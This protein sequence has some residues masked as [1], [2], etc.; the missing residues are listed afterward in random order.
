MN[1]H[2]YCPM[3]P[4]A[5]T[6]VWRAVR[7]TNDHAEDAKGLEPTVRQLESYRLSDP[8]D[9]RS[10]GSLRGRCLART[11]KAAGPLDPPSMPRA[12]GVPVIEPDADT[13][14]AVARPGGCGLPHCLAAR[15]LDGSG[16]VRAGRTRGLQYGGACY[17]FWRRS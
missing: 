14:R 4:P 16:T 11:G 6:T 9:G 2:P 1:G 8:G 15:R 13:R 12:A 7:F 5:L 17:R 10:P 3:R